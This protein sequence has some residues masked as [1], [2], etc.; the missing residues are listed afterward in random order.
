M[1]PGLPLP[2]PILLFLVLNVSH[3]CPRCPTQ[4]PVGSSTQWHLSH[5][6]VTPAGTSAT[7]TFTYRSYLNTNN[8][9]T[10]MTQTSMHDL[11]VRSLLL[12]G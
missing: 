11:Q 12:D 6:D 10:T 9:S 7:S 1:P 4:D 5:V 3:T 8:T 2:I